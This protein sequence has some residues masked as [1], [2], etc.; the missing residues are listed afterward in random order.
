MY[1]TEDQVGE[2]IRGR[3]DGLFIASKVSGHH[4][5]HDDVLQAAENSLRLM[6]EDVIDLYQIHYPNSSI[7]IGETM[8]AMEE[9]VDRGIV[10]YI[11]VSNFSV[12]QLQEAQRAMSKY[13]VVSN[14]VLYNLKSRRIEGNLIPYCEENKVTVIAY[15][16]LADGSLA[17]KPQLLPDKQNNVLQEISQEAGKTPA[18]V[19]LNWCLTRQPVVVIPKTNSVER[20]EENCG[21]TGWQL[22]A[23][24][25]QRLDKGFPL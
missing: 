25:V 12:D 19:A 6:S 24:Q 5:R 16:P 14:Q 22:T 1:R 2:A 8:K 15:T 4:L 9:L 18:Q 3:R 7:P 21:A 10:K 23:D 20:T 13:P 11:G 17:T